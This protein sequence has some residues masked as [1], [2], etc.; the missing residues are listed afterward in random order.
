MFS[1][2]IISTL[3]LFLT[4]IILPIFGWKGELD[5]HDP[6][7]IRS[8]HCYYTFGTGDGHYHEGNAIIRRICNDTVTR[9]GSLFDAQP[10]WIQSL[11]K[12]KPGNIWAPDVNFFNDQY[13]VYYAASHFGSR[14]SVIALASAANI[15]GKWIDHG[16]VLHTTESMHYNAI[17]PEIAWTIVDNKR[18][19]QWL[20]FGSYWEGIKAHKLDMK[21]G[22]LST[23]DTKL[24]SL[25]SRNGGAIEASSVAFRDGFYYLFVSFDICCKGADSTYRVMVGR[26]KHITG[27]YVD[28]N[29]V[30]MMKGGGTQILASH[31]NVRGPGGCDV[32]FDNGVYRMIYHWYDAADHGRSKMDIVDLVWSEDHWPSVGTTSK[33]NYS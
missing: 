9:V 12:M 16:E 18:V 24:Y 7:F 3:V 13:Y 11:L 5:I 20:V 15:E 17:D 27:P 21:T 26:S 22:K 29:G 25:A 19:E 33:L 4:I 14:N 6:S 2:L 28:H 32:I 30:D 23:E 10:S 1:K 31:G 8:G